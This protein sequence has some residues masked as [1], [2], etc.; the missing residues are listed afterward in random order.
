[1]DNMRGDIY[2]IKYIINV[3][4]K[5]NIQASEGKED[6]LYPFYTFSLEQRKFCDEALY[7]GNAI[8]MGTGGKASI[9]YVA[10]KFSTSTDCYNFT[11]YEYTK[12]IYYYLLYQL[13]KID[14]IGFQGIGIKHLQKDFI[15][16]M[17]IYIPHSYKKIAQFLD[18][19]VATIDNIIDKTKET[20][21]DYKKYKQSLITEVVT[22][23]L[24]KNAEMKD[25]G[26]EWIGKIPEN[27]NLVKYKRYC[28]IFAGGTPDTTRIEYY[29]GNIPWIQSGKIQN[30]DVT[31]C[32]RYIT[33]LAVKNSSTK[34][35]PK[36]TALLAM[37]GATCGNVGFSKIDLYANQS[38]MAFVNKKELDARY[39][40]YSLYIQKDG[41][42]TNQNGS[43]QAGIS[44]ENGKNLYM[45]YPSFNEQVKITKILDKKI[46]EID[47]LIAAK[48]N[49]IDELEQYKKSLIY[50]YVTGKKEVK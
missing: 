47:N 32:S 18:N 5:S 48:Q 9:N 15:N 27:W 23:G 24:D 45:P 26:V 36:N 44:V 50:E 16:N 43:A 28:N 6:G 38:V 37:T 49:I 20:I 7:Q 10:D 30:C 19:K 46:H 12:F 22:K 29:N 21:E 40:Y 13:D 2:I 14:L 25:S 1:M 17:K 11:A 39:V 4:K 33:D 42:L 31:D 3:Y 8:T 34:F 35:I 41:I